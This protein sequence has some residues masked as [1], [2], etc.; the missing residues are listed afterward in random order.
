[1]SST[2]VAACSTSC[3]PKLLRATTVLPNSPRPAQ[4]ESFWVTNCTLG[5]NGVTNTLSLTFR[6]LTQ[7]TS[8][9]L[10]TQRSGARYVSTL[11]K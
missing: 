11:S 2:L 3:K 8:G 7:S 4:L 9:A 1:M 5:E 6:S 10:L